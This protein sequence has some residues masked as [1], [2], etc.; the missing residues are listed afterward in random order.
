M[1]QVGRQRLHVERGEDVREQLEVSELLLRLTQVEP[2]RFH[3]TCR[4]Q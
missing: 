1:T 3:R 4:V 2:R